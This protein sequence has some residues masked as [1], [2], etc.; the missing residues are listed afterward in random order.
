M[1]DVLIALTPA[2]VMGVYFFGLRA[3]ILILITVTSCVFFEWGF[4]KATKRPVTVFDLS[5]VVTG[6]L[7]AYNIP[8]SS[9]FWM[10]VAGAF[11]AIVVAKQLFGGIG[12]NFLNP[13][14]AARAFLLAAY[15]REM[16]D[17]TILPRWSV[18][19]STDIVASAT[20]LYNLSNGLMPEQA[21]YINAFLGNIGGSIG[22]TCAWALLWGGVYL[23]IKKVISWRIPVFYGVTL[24]LLAW[25][26]G[27][28]GGWF[29]G[30]PVYELITGGFLLGAIFMATDYT[31]CPITPKGQILFAIGCG[32]LTWFI[33]AGVGYP[34]GVSY[35]ILLMNLTVP[36]IDRYIKPKVFGVQKKRIKKEAEE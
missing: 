33:R 17:W 7:L 13:A 4:Q 30:I 24:A 9:P 6:L 27:R 35:A 36:I 8:S 26:F 22:E 21:D 25:V 28:G 5:A 1:L 14:L 15:P 32:T 16:T 34:E 10:A 31:T 2:G 18:S 3:L 29:T 23:L 20:P 11:V 19:N 12:R